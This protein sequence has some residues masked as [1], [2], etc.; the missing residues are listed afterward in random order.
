ME[1]AV[2]EY[3]IENGRRDNGV[4][5]K[6]NELITSKYSATIL[7]NQLFCLG[8]KEVREEGGEFVA[9]LSA[10]DIK[11]RL[12]E[13]DYHSFYTQL[14]KT[15]VRMLKFNIM[16]ENEKRTAFHAV[17][18]ISDVKYEDGVYQI[19][20]NKKFKD[21]FGERLIKKYTFLDI[22]TMLKFKSSVSLRLY[23]ILKSQCYAPKEAFDKMAEDGIY[24][25]RFDVNELRCMLGCVD[26]SIDKIA[27]LFQ[28]NTQDYDYIME[29]IKEIAEKEKDPLIKKRIT[30]KWDTWRN[31]KRVLSTSLEEINEKTEIHVDMEYKSSGKRTRIG[32]IYF[33]VNTNASEKKGGA[34]NIEEP[35]TK[36]NPANAIEISELLRLLEQAMA[37]TDSAFTLEECKLFLE[38]SGYDVEKIK[39]AYSV[40]SAAKNVDNSVGY[41]VQAIKE[42]W[43]APKAK[44]RGNNSGHKQ[45]QYDF[46]ALQKMI[47]EG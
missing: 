15:S 5:K 46:E 20:F 31:F 25:L 30:P 35:K 17:N 6:S 13:K 11:A 4:W 22:G 12:G 28:G 45:T 3:I 9:T 39:K 43:E 27:D 47:N 21:F 37:V 19:F 36:E 38:T 8:L 41:M 16:M 23:E 42:G 14:K 29:R 2:E 34:D 10:A 1:E 24:R 44:T 40:Y 26:T 18:L 32:H 7:E 33:V